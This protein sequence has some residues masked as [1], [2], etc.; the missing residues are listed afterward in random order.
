MEAPTITLRLDGGIAD[1][2]RID[3]RN[4]AAALLHLAEAVERTGQI[5]TFGVPVR[6]TI[7]ATDEGSFIVKFLL[8]ANEVWEDVVE[9]ITS[10]TG[11]TIINLTTI[12]G[13]VVSVISLLLSR[14]QHGGRPTATISQT[15]E[16]T[17]TYPDGSSVVTRAET[18]LAAND[19]MVT[20]ALRQA[21]DHL[22]RNGIHT[23]ELA[24]GGN[25]PVT[26]HK[27]DLSVFNQ[28]L[29]D[30]V[31]L[32][33]GDKV[34]LDELLLLLREPHPTQ[35]LPPITRCEP[36]DLD[37]DIDNPDLHWYDQPSRDGP[38]LSF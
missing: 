12:A 34:T 26:L 17:I 25:M 37:D 13:T 11:A 20:G 18:L 30:I 6:L 3:A 24:N 1:E 10:P 31:H 16:T 36:L 22:T 14:V 35:S 9:A 19:A 21:F 4:L 32:E 27:D 5:F 15:Y 8:S 29:T 7:Q 38:Y 23:V 2:H 33:N 28:G